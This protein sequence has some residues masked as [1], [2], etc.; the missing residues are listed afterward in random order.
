MEKHHNYIVTAE[1]AARLGV[2]GYRKGNDKV[3]YLVNDFDASV[4]PKEEFDASNPR[5]ISDEE[6]DAF[7]KSLETKK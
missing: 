4:M 2:K 7:I 3:G 5:E 6:A 1:M